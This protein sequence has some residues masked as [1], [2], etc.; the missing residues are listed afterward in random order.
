MEPVAGHDEVELEISRSDCERAGCV[1]TFNFSHP[2][3]AAKGLAKAHLP[4]LTFDPPQRGKLAWKS[5]TELVFTPAA[6]QLP[7][8]HEIALKLSDVPPPADAPELAL[9]APWQDTVQVPHF[10][11]AGKVAS[12]PVIAGKPRFVSLLSATSQV[13]AGPLFMLYDQPVDPAKL[14]KQLRATGL[15][16]RAL[17]LRVERPSSAAQVYDGKL[18]TAYLIAVTVVKLPGDGE[19]VSLAIPSWSETGTRIEAIE[20]NLVANSTFALRVFGG[21]DAYGGEEQYDDE[22]GGGGAST[23]G[24]RAPLRVN[25]RLGFSGAVTVKAVER[26]LTITPKPKN[27]NISTS[28]AVAEVSATLAPGQLYQLAL[29]ASLTDVL[30]N[31]LGVPATFRVRA[32]DL[33][34]SLELPAAALVLE[35][36]HARLPIRGRNLGALSVKVHRLASAVDFIHAM[37]AGDTPCAQRGATPEA[38]RAAAPADRPLNQPGAAAAPPLATGRRPPPRWS[39]SPASASPPRCSTASCWCGPPGWPTGTS[40]PAPR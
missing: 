14:G 21:N 8:G 35:N 30:G 9:T 4:R 40:S 27:L 16:K 24:Q 12:W 7:W 6:G 18:D 13:G 38:T 34:P 28:G 23:S 1:L 10:S 5:P 11:A 39:R 33:A 22:E 26:A 20:K 19:P 2:M 29:A 32:E 31:R 36:G 3:V 15:G 25:W 17:E 37:N